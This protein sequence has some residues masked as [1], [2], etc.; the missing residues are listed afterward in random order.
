MLGFPFKSSTSGEAFVPEDL[1]ARAYE[2]TSMD[3]E[4]KKHGHEIGILYE[5][6]CGLCE[7]L[8]GLAGVTLTEHLRSFSCA[9]TVW[10]NA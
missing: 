4:P 8:H 5:S 3:P 1:C 10:P 9:P 6:L 7:T 2:A